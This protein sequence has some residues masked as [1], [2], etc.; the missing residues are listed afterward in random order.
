MKVEKMMSN[1]DYTDGETIFEGYMAFN[2]DKKSQRPCVLVGHAWDGPN[3]HFNLMAE[4]LSKNGFIGFAID[5]YG[6][7]VRGKLAIDFLNEIF[8]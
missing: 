2:G 1:F 5:V 3:E 7:G 4:T 6:K 8:S